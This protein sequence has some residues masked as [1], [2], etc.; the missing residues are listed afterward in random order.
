[1]HCTDHHVTPIEPRG[2]NI[3]SHETELLLLTTMSIGHIS[4]S[5]FLSY[6]TESHN[7]ELRVKSAFP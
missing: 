1:M 7:M 3:P 2:G 5:Q 4:S 6:F